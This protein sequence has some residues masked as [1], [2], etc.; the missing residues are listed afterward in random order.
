M[1]TILKNL[2]SFLYFSVAYL[3]KDSRGVYTFNELQ[4]ITHDLIKD[5]LT[6]GVFN[7]DYLLQRFRERQEL[8]DGGDRIKCPLA[9]IDETGTPGGFYSKGS[10]LS[11]QTVEHLSAS[12]HSWRQVEEPVVVDKLDIAKN[13]SKHGQLKLVAGKVQVAKG[14][15]AQRMLKGIL[16]DGSA[17]SQ[18][19]DTDQFDGFDSFVQSSGSYG[20]ISSTDLS[21]WA[22]TVTAAGGVLTKALLDASFDATFYAGQGGATMGATTV[23]VFTAIKGLLQGNQRTQNEINSLSGAGNKGQSLVYNGIDYFTSQDITAQ[24]LYHID[25]GHTKLHVHKDHNMRVQSI[26][27]LETVDAILERI[28]LYGNIACSELKYNSTLTGI[29]G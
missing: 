9:I 22:A 15:M 25:E 14:A 20:G 10:A 3:L 12:F 19:N 6:M 2:F 23:G 24:Q 26:K 8:E 1:K 11:L 17:T 21:T 13:A 7:S 18:N 4:A 28:F 5:K 27:D 16:S 29:T